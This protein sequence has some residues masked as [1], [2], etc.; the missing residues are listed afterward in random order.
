MPWKESSVVDERM[1]FVSRHQGRGD[2][3][4]VMSRVRHFAQDWL[5]DS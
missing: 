4:F 3:G 5:K 2:N 1:Q